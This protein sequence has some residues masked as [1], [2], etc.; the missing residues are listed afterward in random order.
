MGEM[1]ARCRVQ[2]EGDHREHR[3]QHGVHD[4]RERAH[5]GLLDDARAR[6]ERA[7]DVLEE[8]ARDH[9]EAVEQD[10]CKARA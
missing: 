4:R 8:E 5:V 6:D 10:G 3:D 1:W 2:A 9:L 7:H